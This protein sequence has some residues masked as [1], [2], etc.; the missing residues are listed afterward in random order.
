[1]NQ[2]ELLLSFNVSCCST[3]HITAYY[4]TSRVLVSDPAIY[5]YQNT[6]QKSKHVKDVSEEIFPQ[7]S[8]II[9][10]ILLINGEQIGNKADRKANS[11]TYPTFQ[12]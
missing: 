1:M 5:W 3:K 8:I 12:E 7:P 9:L 11:M 10:N 2:I 4:S 6:L